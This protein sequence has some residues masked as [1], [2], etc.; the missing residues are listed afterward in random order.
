M[1]ADLVHSPPSGITLDRIATPGLAQVAYLIADDTARA[2]AVIDPRRDVDVYLAWAEERGFQISAILETHIHADFVSGAQALAAASGA[3]LLASRRGELAFAHQQIDD[4]D[5]IAV[6]RLRL[7]AL[8]TPGHT[9]EHL[10][11]LLLDP[12]HGPTP[13]ALYSGDAL[14]VG[15]VGRPDLLGAERTRQ[16]AEQLYHTVVDRLSRLPDGVTV[17]PGHTAGSS[18]GKKI[19]D[20]PFTTIGRERLTNYAFSARS[21]NAFVRMVL[22][23]MPP[24]PTYYPIVK[25]INRA[26]PPPMSELPDPGWLA[27]AEVEARVANGATLIDTRSVEAFN[28]GHI[29]GAYFAGLGDDFVA[30]VGWLAPYDREVILVVETEQALAEAT[31]GLRRIGVDRVAGGLTGG[32]AS[33]REAGRPVAT[34]EPISPEVLAARRA[35][36]GGPVVLD[37]RNDEEWRDGHI[38]EALHRFAGEIAQGA[39]VP[40]EPTQEIAVTCAAGYRS[41]V[42]ASLLQARGYE[43]ILNLT[44]GT[45]AW[46]AAGL[47]IVRDE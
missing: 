39:A 45:N 44:G 24:P 9:P 40:V 23:G 20:A 31:L 34:I 46:R 21:K 38:P 41:T 30:W 35:D 28:A 22:D 3:P 7:R 37:V 25:R 12:E 47:P 26:G 42:A 18:C 1:V 36:G 33:W 43:R 6:G 5:E 14:F 2:V 13:L 16:L 15:D 32:M 27:P 10:A 4:G 8:W 29:P 19:G 11:F 17:F